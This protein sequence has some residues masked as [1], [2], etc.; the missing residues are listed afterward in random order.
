MCLTV[1]PGPVRTLLSLEDAVWASCGPRVTVL[2]ATS[3]Q[4]QVLALPVAR[5]RRPAG[6]LAGQ[7][8]ADPSHGSSCVSG[9][10]EGLL[11]SRGAPKSLPGSALCPGI[12]PG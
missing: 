6:R 2:D 9:I 12:I 8:P 3:L 1:G 5:G 11:R 10:S 7:S 4:T